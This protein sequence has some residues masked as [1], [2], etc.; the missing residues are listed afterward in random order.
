MDEFCTGFY[1]SVVRSKC[2]GV[3][4]VGKLKKTVL[5]TPLEIALV[6]PLEKQTSIYWP[7]ETV[8]TIC[9][10]TLGYQVWCKRG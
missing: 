6:I 2:S 1:S 9:S 7:V 4:W 5:V 10:Y 3:R 8:I